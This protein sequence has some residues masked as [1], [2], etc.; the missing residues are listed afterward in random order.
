MFGGAAVL[1]VTKQFYVRR[2][3][4]NLTIMLAAAVVLDVISGGIVRALYR[5]L[6]DVMEKLNK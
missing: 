3:W 2:K 4:V 6:F 5:P 1:V